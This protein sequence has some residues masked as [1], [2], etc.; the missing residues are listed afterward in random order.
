MNGEIREAAW[1]L[2][3]GLILLSLAIYTNGRYQCIGDSESYGVLDTVSGK[4]YDCY[5]NLIKSYGR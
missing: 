1:I 3:V 2:L 4:V 5:G